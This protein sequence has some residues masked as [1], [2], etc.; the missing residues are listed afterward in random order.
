MLFSKMAATKENSNNMCIYFYH[1]G[2]Y[3]RILVSK[4]FFISIP[5]MVVLLDI[6]LYIVLR[7]KSTMASI[8]YKTMAATKF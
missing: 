2:A 8:T 4:V 5:Y 7:I 1:R 3:I 6:F